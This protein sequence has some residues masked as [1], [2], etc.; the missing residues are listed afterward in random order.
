MVIKI[1]SQVNLHHS[2]NK[3]AQQILCQSIKVRLSLHI[4][5]HIHNSKCTSTQSTGKC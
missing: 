4:S 3:L 1:I 2:E 5:P